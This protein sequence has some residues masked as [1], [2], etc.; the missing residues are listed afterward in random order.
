[1]NWWEVWG[2]TWEPSSSSN[3]A[4]WYSL[5]S[6]LGQQ[7]AS[8]LALQQQAIWA[9]QQSQ[10]SPVRRK[11]VSGELER[12]G[13]TLR[14]AFAHVRRDVWHAREARLRATWESYG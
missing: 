6:P 3:N 1:M 2:N 14:T 5:G 7:Q 9:A 10:W 8:A 4:G 12:R 11:P 13:R